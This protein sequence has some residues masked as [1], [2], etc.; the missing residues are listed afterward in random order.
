MSITVRHAFRSDAVEILRLVHELA[1]YENQSDAVQATVESLQKTIAFAPEH[2]IP[3]EPPIAIEHLPSPNRPARCLLLHTSDGE[4]AGM[5]VYYY[6]YSTWTSQPGI[7]VEDLYVRLQHRRKGYGKRLLSELARELSSIDGGRLEWNVLK[8]NKPSI[9]F[10]QA[11]GA[12]SMDEWVG[13][14]VDSENIVKLAHI[15][16]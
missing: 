12:Q 5:A 11:I 6:N 4:L 16:D 3:N 13:M 15:L 9:E 10:Y 2:D 14:R 1:A 8:W 7:F